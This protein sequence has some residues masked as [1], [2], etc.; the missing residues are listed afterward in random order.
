M[1]DVTEQYLLEF[2]QQVCFLRTDNELRQKWSNLGPP[3]GRPLIRR[4]AETLLGTEYYIFHFDDTTPEG[5]Y[6]KLTNHP[7]TLSGDILRLIRN[8]PILDGSHEIDGDVIMH[9][10]TTELR[11]PPGLWAHPEYVQ[12][13]LAP[14]PLVEFDPEI[15]YQ[16]VPRCRSEIENLLKCQGGACPG[17][18]RSRHVVRLLGKSEAGELIFP[19]YR[20]MR[21]NV[22]LRQW[23]LP[24]YKNWILQII[25]G[26]RYLHAH[27]VVH[28]DLGLDSLLCSEIEREELIQYGDRGAGT[29]LIICNLKGKRGDL[30]AQYS[31]RIAPEVD[32]EDLTPTAG[33]STRSDIYD[34]GTLIESLVYGTFPATS[35][36]EWPVPDA[37]EDLV[38]ACTQA[39]PEKRATL[40][41]VEQ[42]VKDLIDPNN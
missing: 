12:D 21:P 20:S 22:H 17:Y 9:I 38:S 25:S 4:W 34:L 3:T 36:V 29:R 8:L 41:E 10:G 40:A 42:M 2:A 5:Q 27:D 16:K 11:S 33:W 13:L 6:I 18:A 35:A 32:C 7:G 23:T 28:G 30:Q 14:L 26:L 24:T 15:Y 1:D 39:D 31:R 37:L 19:R